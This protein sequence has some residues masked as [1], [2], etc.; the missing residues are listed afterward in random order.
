MKRF[1]IVTVFMLFLASVAVCSLFGGAIRDALSPTVAYRYPEYAKYD[2]E[3]TKAYPTFPKQAVLTDENGQ[4]YVYT[5]VPANEY[6]EEA[7]KVMRNNIEV[8][9]TGNAMVYAVFSDDIQGA[10][11]VDWDTPLSDGQRVKVK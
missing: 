1:G 11:V 10:V 6:P 5:I 3:D 7:F 8:V 4:K 9:Y 2:S